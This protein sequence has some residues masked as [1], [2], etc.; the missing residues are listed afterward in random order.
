MAKVLFIPADN[1]GCGIY[2]IYNIFE[3]L[4]MLN[5][6]EVQCMFAG[7][8]KLGY[9]GQDILFTQRIVSKD[10]FEKVLKMKKEHNMK[11]I[12][13]YDDLVW[14]K[15][16]KLHNYNFF[17]K[18][19][20]LSKN[21]N[22]MKQYLDEVADFVTVSTE[23]LKTQLLDFIPETKIKVIPNMLSI[24]SWC[25]DKTLMIPKDDIFF[26]AGSISHYDNENKK[27]GDF[28][29]PF[30]NF[31]SKQKT[32][33]MGQ[34][35]P[36]FMNPIQSFDWCP[37]T[38]YSKSLYQNTR[39]CKFT[40]APLQNNVFNKCKSDLKYLESCAIGRV[41]LVSDFTD[42]PYTNAHPYQIIPENA[43]IKDIQKIVENCKEHYSE[44]LAY[45]YDYLNNRWLDYNIKSYIDVFT[46]V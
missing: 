26:Y 27:Y 31:L 38:I 28:D 39:N 45:Q 2:R 37:M 18:D 30:A 23:Y 3:Q 4:S 9:I 1:S 29:I 35:A 32:L 14:S 7:I 13:D 36:F 10:G 16:S 33:F 15:N 21:Y 24:N 44:I 34:E 42:S 46:N 25:F 5:F 19:A 12:I 6:A 22:D 17:L 43:S 11:I 40:I 8:T 20:D 41:C